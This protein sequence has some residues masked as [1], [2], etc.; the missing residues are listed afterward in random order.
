[1]AAHKFTTL[2]QTALSYFDFLNQ[3]NFIIVYCGT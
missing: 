1:M 2:E 3:I